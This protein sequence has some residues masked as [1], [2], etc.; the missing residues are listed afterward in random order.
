MVFGKTV[1]PVT[2]GDITESITSEGQGIDQGLTQT[3][4]A[5]IANIT[6]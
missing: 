3:K 4:K 5:A 6:G 1:N 2:G